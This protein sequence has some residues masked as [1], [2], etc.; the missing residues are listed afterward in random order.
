MPIKVGKFYILVDF[1]ELGMKEDSQ[2]PIILGRPF[3]AT[4]DAIINV[5]N[6]KVSLTVG[7]EKAEFH[8]SNKVKRS[9]VENSYCKVGILQQVIT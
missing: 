7:E 1:V 9:F 8:L 2:I 5:K 6:S 3:L 4:A